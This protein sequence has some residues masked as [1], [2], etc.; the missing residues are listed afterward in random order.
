MRQINF[1]T[2]WKIQLNSTD[3]KL[4][5]IALTE[6]VEMLNNLPEELKYEISKLFIDS[7]ICHF[8]SEIVTYRNVTLMSLTNKLVCYLSE[9][10]EFYRRDFFKI[11]KGYL[12]VVAMFPAVPG[13]SEKHQ[14]DIFTC[15]NIIF[16]R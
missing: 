15:I 11:L 12:R 5:V 7:D 4:R 2:R 8:L 13:D 3:S 16:K 6:I 1:L 9:N 14:I 10:E